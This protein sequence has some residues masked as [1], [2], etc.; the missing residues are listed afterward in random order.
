MIRR[1]LELPLLVILSGVG[2][3]AMLFPAA[4]AAVYSN[5]AVARP[6]FYGAVIFLL[7]SVLVGIATSNHRPRQAARSQ[8]AALLGAYIWLPFLF[9]IPFNEAVPD[10]SFG[11]AWFEMVSSFTTTG[12]TQ[13]DTPGRLAPSLHLWRALVG[14]MGGFFVLMSAA[15]ILA[16]LNLGGVEVLSGRVP[17]RGAQGADQITHA[18]GPAERMIRHSMVLFPAYFGLTVMLWVMLLIA[19]E[20]GM[21]AL[22]LALSTLSTSGITNGQSLAAADGGRVA[23]ILV[24]AFMALALTRRSLPGAVLTDRNRPILDDHEVR[25]ALFFLAVVPGLLFLRHWVGA[26]V[27]DDVWNASAALQALWGGLFTTMSFLTTTGFES[28]D[29]QDARL[30]SGL[31]SPGLVLLGLAMMG[32]GI[33]TTA[34]GLKLLRVYSLARHGEREMDRLVH[35]S[36]IGGG[37]DGERQ[38]RQ[39]GAYVAWI[40]FMLYAV[41]FAIVIAALSLRGMEFEQSLILTISAVTTTGPLTVMAAEGPIRMIELSMSEKAILGAAMIVGRVEI[42]AI[43]ALLSPGVWR[44]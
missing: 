14:W 4:H 28:A 30:W 2:A 13:Y 44:R 33:A 18:A 9:A 36:S 10:T 12:V 25:L 37:G 39:G 26:L 7:F 38:L 5:F 19:G 17:G 32:G 21:T 31:N 3:L 20:R 34:G 27:V 42:L 43:L 16:P 6:F 22:C 23:E 1:I 35:P 41:T 11:N 40:F 15:A 29:W 8:L 24:F